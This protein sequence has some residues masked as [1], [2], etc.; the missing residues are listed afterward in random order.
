MSICNL[1]AFLIWVIHVFNIFSIYTP[2]KLIMKRDSA[3][4]FYKTVFLF[5]CYL[6]IFLIFFTNEVPAQMEMCQSNYKRCLNQSNIQYI[7]ES[8]ANEAIGKCVIENGGGSCLAEKIISN[9]SNWESCYLV[10]DKV[11]WTLYDQQIRVL[12][13]C[14]SSRMQIVNRCM[15]NFYA[16]PLSL[17]QPNPL[18]FN[19]MM[20]CFQNI[21]RPPQ[22]LRP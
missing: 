14:L 22:R 11:N 4:Y 7:C 5:K 10:G 12:P 15:Q 2:T 9:S 13:A 3:N 17:P 20:Q 6:A 19:E 21:S 1:L 16:D 18:C 8:N